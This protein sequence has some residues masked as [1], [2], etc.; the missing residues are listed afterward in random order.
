MS[1]LKP[2]VIFSQSNQK[3]RCVVLKQLPITTKKQK[4][5]SFTIAHVI[6]NLFDFLFF[7]KKFSERD[8]FPSKVAFDGTKII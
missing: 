7:R 5:P 1:T 3:H 6:P 8:L 2:A 4:L